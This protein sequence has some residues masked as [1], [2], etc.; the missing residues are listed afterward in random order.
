MEQF[1]TELNHTLLKYLDHD[2]IQ[3]LNNVSHETRVILSER[4]R[5]PMHL[6]MTVRKVLGITKPHVSGMLVCGAAAP[7]LS[8]ITQ[9]CDDLDRSE[10]QCTH[11]GSHH[12]DVTDATVTVVALPQTHAMN[13]LFCSRGA[14][15]MDVTL[16]G[17]HPVCTKLGS[18]ML[19][20]SAVFQGRP[21]RRQVSAQVVCLTPTVNLMLYQPSVSIDLRY[22]KAAFDCE[23]IGGNVTRYT[24]YKPITESIADNALCARKFIELP[25]MFTL[26]NSDG[27]LDDCD[28]QLVLARASEHHYN[29]YSAEDDE[30]VVQQVSSQPLLSAINQLGD[31][32]ISNDIDYYVVT[33]ITTISGAML[34]HL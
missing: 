12:D 9:Q 15:S 6:I 14:V 22:I 13:R 30:I 20:D 5:L 31:E 3:L 19:T 11:E 7:L 29:V 25:A 17:M 26:D 23:R 16:Y 18:V 32:I 21:E 27:I 33:P 34:V 4:N 1:S 24:C 8:G 28:T 10:V 2:T